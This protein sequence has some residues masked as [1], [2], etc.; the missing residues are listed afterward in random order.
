MDGLCQRPGNERWFF[1]WCDAWIRV[2]AVGDRRGVSMVSRAAKGGKTF[3]GMTTNGQRRPSSNF[4]N[5][6]PLGNALRSAPVSIRR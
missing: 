6:E 2:T 3:S 1:I 4:P 5:V